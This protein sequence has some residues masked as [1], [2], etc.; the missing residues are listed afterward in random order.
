M[1]EEKFWNV[2]WRSKSATSAWW[3]R[4]LKTTTVTSWRRGRRS[5]FHGVHRKVSSLGSSLTP[6]TPGNFFELKTKQ[7][8][9]I[10]I[11]IG[12]WFNESFMQSYQTKPGEKEPVKRLW[13]MLHKH[14]SINAVIFFLRHKVF[15]RKNRQVYYLMHPWLVYFSS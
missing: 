3:G 8:L 2:N 5:R 6:V 11:F 4:C 14:W 9:L 12:G 7:I 1:T 13:F 15:E 10:F